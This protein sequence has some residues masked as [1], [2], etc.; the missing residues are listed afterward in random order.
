[1]S[2]GSPNTDPSKKP[3]KWSSTDIA[4]LVFAILALILAV[5]FGVMYNWDLRPFSS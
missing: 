3:T 1:M 4:A 5:A 2:S